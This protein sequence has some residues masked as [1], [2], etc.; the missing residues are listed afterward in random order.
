MR[1]WDPSSWTGGPMSPYIYLNLLTTWQ[2]IQELSHG[3][4]SRYWSISIDTLSS[5]YYSSACLAHYTDT[6][7]QPSRG[8][9]GSKARFWSTR[10][11]G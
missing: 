7:I 6:E 3:M 1:G 5:A 11:D 9:A 2:G 4:W 10:R 8:E